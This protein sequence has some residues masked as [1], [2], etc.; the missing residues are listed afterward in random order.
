MPVL[1]LTVGLPGCGKTTWTKEQL[2]KANSKTVNVNLDDLRETMSGSHEQ[3]K[4]NSANEKYVQTVQCH[5]AEIAVSNSWNIIVSDTNLN[6]DVRKKWKDFAK[7]HNY[8]YRE[9]NFFNEFKKGKTFEHEFFAINAFVKE[10]K[11]RNIKRT[12]VV[13]DS[14]ID[15]M[16]SKYFYSTLP[17]LKNVISVT[18]D[19]IIVDID[20]TVAHM[21][22]KRGPYEE[23]KVLLDDPDLEVIR[24]VQAEKYY[25]NRTVIFVSGRHDVCR[26]S[27]IQWLKQNNVPFDYLYMRKADDNRPDDVVKYEIYMEHIYGKFNVCKV[28]DDRNKVVFMWRNLLNLKVYQV[29]P[30]DF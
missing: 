15:M 2:K 22:D 26:D 10:C 24:S 8:T 16:A 19:A 7:Q 13:P 4:F 12:K 27:T 29:N 3:Y 30:G 28:F 21:N 5:S 25:F 18:E 17:E 6:P 9:H 14:I 20:G 1:T 23:D 11:E